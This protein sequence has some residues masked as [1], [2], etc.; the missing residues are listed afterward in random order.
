M[1]TLRYLLWAAATAAL[2]ACAPLPPPGVVYVGANFGPPP[3]VVE[4]VSVAPG[5]GWLWIRGFYR[6]DGVAYLWVPGRWERP[7]HPRAR[8]EEGRW[9]HHARG[10]Y[11]VEGRWR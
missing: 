2:A 3:P 5:R 10:W 11:W 4:V 9:R 6:W 7:P 8:W 1:K